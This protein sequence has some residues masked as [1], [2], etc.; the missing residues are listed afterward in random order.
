MSFFGHPAWVRASSCI[1]SSWLLVETRAYP[2]SRDDDDLMVMSRIEQQ[3]RLDEAANVEIGFRDR[4]VVETEYSGQPDPVL[5]QTI[6][7]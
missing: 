6:V 5:H 7:L 1:L 3:E 2:T 4:K